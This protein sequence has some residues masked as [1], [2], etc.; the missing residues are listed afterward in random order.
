MHAQRVRERALNFH[1]HKFSAWKNCSHSLSSRPNKLC[2]HNNHIIN[3]II[4]VI[5]T[6]IGAMRLCFKAMKNPFQKFKVMLS[7]CCC[8]PPLSAAHT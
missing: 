6:V 1:C 4:I 5:V 3:V 7:T 2:M 8:R